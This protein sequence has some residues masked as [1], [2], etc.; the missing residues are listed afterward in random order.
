MKYEQ[1]NDHKKYINIINNNNIPGN[2][3]IKSPINTINKQSSNER[4]TN[5]LISPNNKS[6]KFYT[7]GSSRSPHIKKN[8]AS[9]KGQLQKEKNL[10]KTTERIRNKSDNTWKKLENNKNYKNIQNTKKIDY[11]YYSYFPIKKIIHPFEHEKTEE[12][13]YWFA[14]YDKLIKKKKIFKIFSFYNVASRHS[15]VI[16]NNSIYNDF[17]KIKEKKMIIPNYE[18]YFIEKYNRPF[19]RKCEE[20]YIYVKLYLLN[21]KQINMIFSY[22][23]RIEF[24]IYINDLNYLSEKDSYKKISNIRGNIYDLNYSSI[25]CLGTYMNKNIYCLSRIENKEVLHNNY[26]IGVDNYPNSKKIAKLIKLLMINFPENSKE[27]FIN[28]IFNDSHNNGLNKKIL[29]DKKNEINHLLIS[30]KKS[31]YKANSKN[32]LNMQSIISG[33]PEF[34][35]SPYFS[36]NTNNMNNSNSNIISNANN[37]NNNNMNNN[38]ATI[39]YNASCF[40][41]T[42]DVFN[43]LKRNEETIIKA[44]ESFRSISN[45]N[46]NANNKTIYNNYT[47]N[48]NN[49]LINDAKT[50]KFSFENDSKNCQNFIKINT[51]NINKDRNNNDKNIKK[52]KKNKKKEYNLPIKRIMKVQLRKKTVNCFKNDHSSNYLT[53]KNGKIS[54]YS[55]NYSAATHGIL[56]DNKENNYSLMNLVENNKTKKTK[57]NLTDLTLIKVRKLL[58]KIKPKM[59]YN[60]KTYIEKNNSTINKNSVRGEDIFRTTNIDNIRKIKKISFVN[61]KIQIGVRSTDYQKFKENHIYKIRQNFSINNLNKLSKTNMK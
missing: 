40:D 14:V 37:V 55:F 6:I 34:S 7:K 52:D 43:S 23:N 2:T 41:F 58:E 24:K 25:H 44:V 17:S 53:S 47:S 8:C 1:I 39:S 57:S 15:M 21:L 12:E 11:R 60:N 18:L 30:K 22:L 35:F 50:S 56:E 3:Y 9:L 46:R 19:I 32:D 45:K 33:I 16:G 49:N 10:N 31:L 61:K 13:Y 27:H 42:S 5:P 48:K 29:T 59:Q 51:S 4:T 26:S 54:K 20:K 38:L 36:S 28:Y